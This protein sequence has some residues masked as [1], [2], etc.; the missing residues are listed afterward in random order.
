MT[1]PLTVMLVA[2]EASGDVLGASLA[3]ALKRRLGSAV[4]FVGVGGEAMAAEGVDSPFDIAEL[5]ILG[6]FEGLRAL[7]RV[8]RRA[9]QT[10]E[11]AR[12]EKPDIAVLIDSWGFNLR[13]AHRLRALDP[14]LPLVKYVAPQ[15]WASRPGRAK[16]LARSVDHLLS[17]NPLDAGFFE[18]EGLATTFV[19]NPALA[20]LPQAPD[21]A[22][23]RAHVGAEPHDPIVMIAPGSRPSEIARLTPPFQDAAH[24]LKARFPALKIVIPLAATVQDEVAATAP[25][26]PTETFLLTDADLKR[27]A[28]SGVTAALACSGTLTLELAMAGRAMVVAYRVG[29]L[30]HVLLKRLIITRYITLFNIAAGE[31][32]APEFVQDACTGEALAAAVGER[33]ADPALRD[34]QVER[35]NAALITMGRGMPD[36]SDTAAD[37]LLL[38]LGEA[39]T[40]KA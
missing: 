36:P 12:L 35:Q 8:Q 31:E 20:R 15:V 30:T 24:R 1:R 28:M 27:D 18:P 4:R 39:R 25:G 34:A 21:M 19:G 32:I 29:A 17:I 38:L 26:W 2:G 14:E 23:L 40:G 33:L 11:L 6:L 7:P 5:S 9:R 10:A 3:Q 22:R 13:V 37:A 16:T